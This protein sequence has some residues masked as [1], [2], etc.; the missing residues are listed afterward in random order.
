MTP[1]EVAGGRARQV[2]SKGG[3]ATCASTALTLH[4]ALPGERAGDSGVVVSGQ[5]Q[6]WT[7]HS[8]PVLQWQAQR[9]ASQCCSRFSPK[10]PETR[11]LETLRSESRG[12]GYGKRPP[13]PPRGGFLREEAVDK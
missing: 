8:T 1:P 3:P 13:P 2:L 10:R 12:K 11:G 5:G 9:Q 7:G 4:P 6:L